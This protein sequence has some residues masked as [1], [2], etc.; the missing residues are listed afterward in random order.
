MIVN[1]YCIG[2]LSLIVMTTY[3]CQ[4]YMTS[5]IRESITFPITIVAVLEHMNYL[6]YH[7]NLPSTAIS[8]HSLSTQLFCG[9]TMHLYSGYEIC[10]S[11]FI[12]PFIVFFV[13]G[14]VIY[15]MIM[16]MIMIMIKY[17][18]RHSLYTGSAFNHTKINTWFY[19]SKSRIR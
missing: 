16:T 8:I 2:P 6:L 15:P 3:L 7:Y 10:C 17:Q 19:K 12:K 5:F 14:I 1:A 9:I 4:C 11:P 13:H 18:S